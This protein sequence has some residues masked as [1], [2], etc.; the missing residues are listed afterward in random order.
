MVDSGRREAGATPAM[1]ADDWSGASQ[2]KAWAAATSE[3][4]V[5]S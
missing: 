3:E 2:S 1:I 5:V 4:K